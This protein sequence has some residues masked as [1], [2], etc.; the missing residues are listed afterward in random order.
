MAPRA[1]WVEG[2]SALVALGGTAIGDSLRVRLV[3]TNGVVATILV[4]PVAGRWQVLRN[5]GSDRV[6]DTFL[7]VEVSSGASVA[8][9]L[10][11]LEVRRPSPNGIVSTFLGG[12]IAGILGLAAQLAFHWTQV[13][14]RTRLARVQHASWKVQ[15]QEALLDADVSAL[16]AL[17][18]EIPARLIRGESRAWENWATSVSLAL[19]PDGELRNAE[20]R[21]AW[22]E[23]IPSFPGEP[24]MRASEHVAR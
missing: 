8:D 15:W 17:L 12:L 24:G 23:G 6:G 21:K 1:V 4:R 19:R 16:R 5:I 22:R 20:A 11:F 3:S 2:D 13:R 18:R 10:L 14:E 9:T 7:T